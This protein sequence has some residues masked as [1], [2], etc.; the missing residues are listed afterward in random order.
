MIEVEFMV[1]PNSDV[2]SQLR[3]W[4]TILPWLKY[5]A[6]NHTRY[7]YK[8]NYNANTHQNILRLRFDLPPSKETYY[9]LKY[10]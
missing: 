10:R 2:E 1:E 6:D 7:D 9:N 8:V 3:D 5:L 4:S